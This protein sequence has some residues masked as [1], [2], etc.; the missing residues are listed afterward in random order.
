[1]VG[2][3]VDPVD[4]VAAEAQGGGAVQEP[5]HGILALELP[6][7]VVRKPGQYQQLAQLMAEL[8]TIK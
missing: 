3:V 4:D 5:C 8:G 2:L 6:S 7:A 1:V